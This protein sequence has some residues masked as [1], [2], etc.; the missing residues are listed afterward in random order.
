MCL[1]C[2]H[3]LL[4]SRNS[5][6]YLVSASSNFN[7]SFPAFGYRYRLQCSGSSLVV[8]IPPVSWRHHSKVSHSFFLSFAILPFF[9]L[10]S[11]LLVLS[12]SGHL[13]LRAPSP[14]GILC[15][16]ATLPTGTC[17]RATFAFG[18]A[19]PS[20]HLADGHLADGPPSNSHTSPL[21][22]LFSLFFSDCLGDWIV[23]VLSGLQHLPS[24]PL[25]PSNFCFKFTPDAA[26]HN[27]N[28]L[29]DSGF[30]LHNALSSNKSS[31]LSFGSEFK[32]VAALELLL[33]HHPLWH[34]VKAGLE[35]GFQ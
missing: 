35:Q 21:L 5:T 29:R 34:R 19:L 3:L 14:S 15:P 8:L 27:S 25:L 13:C 28:I 31:T 24:Q 32:P 20:G 30:D 1:A 33:K 18:Q 16:R 17:R 9:P 22:F 11:C 26:T 4:I 23:S 6:L 2:P 10:S 12:P 7:T